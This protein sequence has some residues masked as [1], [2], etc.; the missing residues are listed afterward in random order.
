MIADD[1]PSNVR[2]LREMIKLRFNRE[3]VSFSNGFEAYDFLL[4]Y[5]PCCSVPG[6]LLIL[7][8]MMPE[9]NGYDTAEKIKQSIFKNKIRNDVIMIG[10]TALNEPKMKQLCLLAGMKARL[11]KPLNE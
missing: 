10:L 3:V 4:N 11:K 5:K 6:R 9:M 1:E 7:D 8:I 2:L